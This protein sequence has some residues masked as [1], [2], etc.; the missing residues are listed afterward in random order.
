MQNGLHG[1]GIESTNYPGMF[2]TCGMPRKSDVA[3]QIC[4][5]ARSRES[6]VPDVC[7]KW[8]ISDI[9]NGKETRVM[10]KRT[11][12]T[13][14]Y[15]AIGWPGLVYVV[16]NSTPRP[17]RILALPYG[18]CVY[19]HFLK[20]SSNLRQLFSVHAREYMHSKVFRA[21]RPRYHKV[22]TVLRTYG[23]NT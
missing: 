14:I 12:G 20:G 23:I 19:G 6:A 22:E 4:T 18:L 15:D 3:V 9:C 17:L 11:T 10:L 7:L 2:G 13:S 16:W 8:E 21:F 1:A 5:S